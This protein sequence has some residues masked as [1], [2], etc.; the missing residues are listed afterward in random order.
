MGIK[1]ECVWRAEKDCVKRGDMMCAQV[2]L[3]K[4]MSVRGFHS[5]ADISAQIFLTVTSH[6]SYQPLIICIRSSVTL[7]SHIKF[8]GSLSQDIDR[9]AA[10]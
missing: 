7:K 3:S 9:S 4:C 5:K 2:L 8:L 1:S 6:S 10:L